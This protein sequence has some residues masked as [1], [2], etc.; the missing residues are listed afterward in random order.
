M[1]PAKLLLITASVLLVSM[2]LSA[3]KDAKT[4]ND[5][6]T[7]TSSEN[8]RTVAVLG[9]KAATSQEAEFLFCLDLAQP[10]KIAFDGLARVIYR[11]Q[12]PPPGIPAGVKISGPESVSS[13]LAVVPNEGK[14]WVFVAKGEK[15]PLPAEDPAMASATTVKVGQ[16]RRLDW[17]SDSGPRRGTDLEG[18]LSPGG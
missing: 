18:C 16:V 15:T 8:G 7:V 13:A 2:T 17:A 11:P 5:Y 14:A 10:Q 3:E 4:L 9:K 1:K 6:V 12:A